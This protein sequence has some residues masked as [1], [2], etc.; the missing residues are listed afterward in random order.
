MLKLLACLFMLIDHI[1]YYFYPLMPDWLS[2]LMR[3]AGRLAF[4]MFAWGIALGYTRTRNPVVYFFRMAVFAFISEIVIRVSHQAAGISWSG[5]NVLVTFALSI[6]MISGYRLAMHSFFDVIGS[7]RPVSSGGD[8]L[9]NSRYD[10]KLS[11]RGITLDPRAGLPA[12]LLMILMAAFASQ[13][14]KPDY[15]LY[16]LLTI[17]LFYMARDLFD[18]TEHLKKSLQFFIL[19]NAVFLIIRI[20]GEAM[21][22][23]WAIVQT[24]SIV[25]LPL[26]EQYQ[27]GRKPGRLVKYFFYLFYPG[28]LALLALLSSYLTALG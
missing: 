18:E 15:G 26:C 28:H 27:H 12:G 10:V 7:L 17:T 4:P 23:D 11:L 8:A 2:A 19:L 21:P 3:L 6:V 5:T 25:A 14:L 13:I 16:G 20:T 22:V 9:S 1:G 24:F